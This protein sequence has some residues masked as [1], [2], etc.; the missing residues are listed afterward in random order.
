MDQSQFEFLKIKKENEELKKKLQEMEEK[1]KATNLANKPETSP[2]PPTSPIP[3]PGLDI[4]EFKSPINFFFELT[5][6][7]EI[8]YG[9]I[10]YPTLP[11][12]S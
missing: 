12:T 4:F 5:I 3:P 9:I 7:F 2:Q 8:G 6:N 1:M 10:S 11:Q